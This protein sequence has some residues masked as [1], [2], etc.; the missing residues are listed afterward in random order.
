MIAS[1]TPTMRPPLISMRPTL[2]RLALAAAA[3]LAPVA[4][5]AHGG[6]AHGAAKTPAVREQTDWGIA[7]DPASV[8]RTIDIRMLDTMRFVPDRIEVREGQTVRLRIRNA[9][10]VMH[11]L[12]LGTKAELDA[13]AALMMK[14]P[15]ME[16][17]EP[18]MAHVEPGVRGEI[19]WLFNRAGEFEFACLIPGHYQAG[20]V[21]RIRVTAA[22]GSR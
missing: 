6:A 3:T 16:H 4:A 2:I 17:D 1:E 13:H 5:A 20:M 12:V 21:G 7:G 15:N 10:R 19:V 8:V 22:S 18:H 9:G 14:F 11:E